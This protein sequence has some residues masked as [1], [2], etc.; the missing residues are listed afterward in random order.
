MD[1]WYCAF[2]VSV[3]LAVIELAIIIKQRIWINDLSRI[4]KLY[5]SS[6]EGEAD[7]TAK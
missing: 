4:A 3:G 7:G 5:V 2:A 6:L 1:W